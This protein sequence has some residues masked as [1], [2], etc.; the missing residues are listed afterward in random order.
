M[1][2]MS[3]LSVI[4]S[5][6]ESSVVPSRHDSFTRQAL[7]ELIVETLRAVVRGHDVEGRIADHLAILS[8]H[9][10]ATDNSL[11][12]IVNDAIAELY[13][14]ISPSASADPFDRDL[15]GIVCDSLKLA[16]ETYA[17]NDVA[18]GA[19]RKRRSALIGTIEL[20]I[21]ECERR[22]RV[23]GWSYVGRL[24]GNWFPAERGAFLRRR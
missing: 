6:C 12:S 5:G 9:A 22:S 17:D 7:R 24:L 19:A 21:V 15:D 8:K 18:K 2:A 13:W 4:E 23:N 20:Y 16:A 3:T 10:S 11:N 1:R 14:K